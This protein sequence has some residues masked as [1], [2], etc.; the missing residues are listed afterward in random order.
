VNENTFVK[1]IW[2]IGGDLEMLKNL[3]AA[4]FPVVIETGGPFAEGYD[5]IGHYQ[6]V[7]GYDDNQRQIYLY[8]SYLGTGTN[9]EGLAES[10]DI[11]DD[12]WQDFNRVFIVVYEPDRE[13]EV[14]RILGDR[15]DPRQAAQIA[16]ETAQAEAPLNPADPIPWFNMGTAF[17][18]L[19]LYEEAAAAYD[20][21]MRQGLP[22][23]MIWYQFG[24][25]EAYY[26]VG[27]YG[28]VDSIA[29]SV[30]NDSRGNVEEAYYW[31]GR[32]LE[33]QGRTQEAAS[34][35]NSALRVN[36]LFADARE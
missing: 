5:W 15:A 3:V 27:R 18:R 29:Q 36:P 28:D 32:A 4:N 2:R 34:A 11:F 1:A 16:L 12:R 14:A 25:F 9:G 31:R 26:N 10:Y 33:A 6:T 13:A 21:A 24:I 19:G 17:L 23:R 30:I 20:N 8:D 35:Y 22:F 7:V